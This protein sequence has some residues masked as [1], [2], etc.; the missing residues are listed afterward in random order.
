ML[1]N[2]LQYMTPCKRFGFLLLWYMSYHGTAIK[3]AP[4]MV[5]HTSA[6]GD[7]FVNAVSKQLTLSQVAQLPH[8]RLQQDTTSQWHNLHHPHLHHTC[9][10]HPLHL[11]HWKPR[12][13]RFQLFLPCQLFKRMSWNQ[14]LWHPMP[15]LCSHKDPAMP[16]WHPNAW[17]RKSKNYWPRL[18]M[19]L[20]LVTCCHIHPQSIVTELNCSISYSQNG[21]C[22]IIICFVLRTDP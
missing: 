11:Q 19:D 16:T 14:C 12:W 21:G 5:P 13:T 17:S 6:C 1:A 8:F 20:V 2:Q 10:P 3:Y 9:S 22:C 18:S 7:T 4:A 15:H